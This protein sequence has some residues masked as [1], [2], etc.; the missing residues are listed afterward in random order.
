D[1]PDEVDLGAAVDAVDDGDDDVAGDGGD[2]EP[3]QVEGTWVVQA[4]PGSFN[5]DESDQGTY[6]GFRV[7]EQLVRGA[8]T[9]VGRTPV[10]EGEL[11]IE[12]TTL[13]EALVTADLSEITTSES[14][15][16]SR[17]RSALSTG[18]FPEATFPLTEPVELGE[19][20]TSGGPV[21]V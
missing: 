8:A 1:A 17:V 6:V 19:A 5:Y 16:D 18:E 11:G 9:A 21:S 10:V 4:D 15:R 14:M 20:A 7:E 12:G 13:A 2:G 3:V